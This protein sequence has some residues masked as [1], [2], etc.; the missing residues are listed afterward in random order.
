M[1]TIDKFVYKGGKMRGF[2]TSRGITPITDGGGITPP[3]RTG[4]IVVGTIDDSG[5]TPRNV[6][7]DTQLPTDMTPEELAAYELDLQISACTNGGGTWTT[8]GCVANTG[9]D[10]GSDSGTDT[11][12]GTDS[13]TDDGTDIGINDGIGDGTD[14]GNAGTGTNPKGDCGEFNLAFHCWSPM[15]K[16]IVVGGGIALIGYLIFKSNK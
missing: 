5:T 9:G 11:D 16:L 1:N 12:S 4:T 2:T 3:P 7:F 10:T 13:G 8:S 14:G 15:Q 6:I